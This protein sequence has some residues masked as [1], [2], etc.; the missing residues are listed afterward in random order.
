MITYCA[1]TT[2][3]GA[4]SPDAEGGIDLLT[5]ET[6]QCEVLGDSAYGTGEARA[7]LTETG[8][9]AVTKTTRVR[10]VRPGVPRRPRRGPR[11]PG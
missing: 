11:R 6:E 1:L 9:H 2:A 5:D 4:G 3:G 7:T 8:H 10:G